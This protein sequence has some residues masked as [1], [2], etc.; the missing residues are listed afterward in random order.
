[1]AETQ[2]NPILYLVSQIREKAN[3]LISEELIKKG[4]KGMA[5]SHGAIIF[6]LYKKGEL[7]MKEIAS[8]INKDKS[9]VTALIS[10]LITHGYVTKQKSAS[11]ARSS[12][13]V[14]TQKGIDFKDDFESVSMK[15][16]SKIDNSI[17]NKEKEQLINILIKLNENW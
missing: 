1:M 4:I 10:K 16:F 14:L 11:D 8:Y 6:F 7:T 5:P 15:L 12:I 13:I 9:T 2:F 17:T 3:K